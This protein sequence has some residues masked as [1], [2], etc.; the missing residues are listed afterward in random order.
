[1]PVTNRYDGAFR[2]AHELHAGGYLPFTSDDL[3]V[4][5]AGVAIEPLSAPSFEGDSDHCRAV[6]PDVA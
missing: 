3:L 6:R 2:F 5:G 4:A 1:M